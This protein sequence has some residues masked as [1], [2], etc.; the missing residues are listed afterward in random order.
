MGF[1]SATVFEETY[2]RYLEEVG[3]LNLPRRAPILG[4][5]MDGQALVLDFYGTRYAVSSTGIK[6]PDGQRPPFSA[7]VV[8][9]KYILMCP[10]Q[11][12]MPGEDWVT[13]RNFKDA[14]PLVSYFTTNACNALE[15]AFSG[16]T[17]ELERAC[18]ALGGRPG[19]FRESYDLS[20]LVHALPRIPVMINFNDGDEEFPAA[21][22]IL[23]L[24]TTSH[25]L[26]MESVAI[27]GTFLAG[28][29]I[30]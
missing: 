21:A 8:M 23:F 15:Q 14:G 7:A 2:D 28:R 4:G 1:G 18:A 9:L 24:K 25:Y 26:D 13:F 6:G 17:G 19:L 27:A 29:L 12:V 22:S 3:R 11:R 5:K 16:K 20:L 30:R 10:D